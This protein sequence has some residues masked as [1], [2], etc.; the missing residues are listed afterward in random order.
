MN[1]FRIIGIAILIFCVTKVTAQESES[2]FKV[3]TYNIWN[4]FNWGKD[5]IRH[6]DWI[7]WI[8]SKK[9]NVL[10]LQELCGYDEEK[11]K[12]DAAKWGHQYVKILKSE[13][14]PVGLTSNKPITLK[15][16]AIDDFWHGLLHCE[17]YGIDFF[18][19]HLS[20]ADVEFR[21]KEAG[22]IAEKAK[23]IKNDKFIILGDFNAHSPFDEEVLKRNENLHKKY[24]R[25]EN[26]SKY[27]NLRYGEFDYSVVSTFLAVPAIDVSQSFIDISNRYTFPS[28]VLLG[29]Y[30]KTMDE[31]I[32]TRERIDYILTSPIISKLCTN[33]TIYNK[34]ETKTFSDHY[35]IMAEFNLEMNK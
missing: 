30:R 8:K 11:L 31:V 24:L 18:V 20:P 27:S 2:T 16:R 9:P 1:T 14:Y 17:T 28:P 26:K 4:G 19:V 13:G 5:T 23:K 34:G 7:Q 35:P 12:V 21:L 15:E 10:A 25:N 3:M 33:V 32:Q 29:S 22:F 6:A